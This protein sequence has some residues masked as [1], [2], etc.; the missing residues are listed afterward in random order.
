VQAIYYQ[1]GE[2]ALITQAIDGGFNP[3]VIVFHVAGDL[4]IIILQ[5]DSFEIQVRQRI[6]RPDI[7]GN[8]QAFDS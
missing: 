3:P 6:K 8:P 1:I 5:I 7:A 2:K 4:P